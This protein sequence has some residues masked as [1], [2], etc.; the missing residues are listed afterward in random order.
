MAELSA[1]ANM[2]RD[3]ERHADDQQPDRLRATQYYNGE[4]MD[5]LPDAGRSKAVTRDVRAHIKKALPSICRTLLHGDELVEF[6][7]KGEGDEAGA[8]QSSDYINFVVL[9]ESGGRDA[10]YDAIHDALLLRNGILK[11][12]VDER[13]EVSVSRHS[14]IPSEAFAEL[15]AGD[16]VEVL[17]HTEREEMVEVDGQAVPFPVHDVKLRRTIQRKQIKAS[18]V[19]RERFLIHPDAVTFEDSLLTG[20]RTQVTRSDLVAMGYD[21]ETVDGIGRT[22]EDNTEEV[23]RRDFLSDTD[24]QTKANELVDY[25]EIFVRIDLD[26]DGIAEL[27]RMCFAGGIHEQNLLLNEECDEVQFCDL[28]AMRQPHQWE[29]ISIADDLM[30]LQR[31]KTVL[32]R[33]TLDN[34]YWTN[35]PQPVVNSAAIV[36]LDPVVN[37]DFGKAIQLNDGYNVR[38]AI[39]WN[40]IPFV[41]KE[42]FGMMDYIDAEAR[43]RT[44]ISEASAGMAPDALQNVTAKASAMIE[45]SGIGQTEMIVRNLAQ[46]LRRFFR[47]LLRLTI[48]HQD[49]PR[50]VRLRDEWVQIDPRQWNADMDCTVNTG[51]GAGTRERDMAVMGQVIGLQE[52]LFAAFGP[53]NPFVKP[54]NVYASISRMVEAAGLK[55]PGLYFT[56]PNPQEIAAKMQAAAQKPDPE[57]QKFQ[58]QMQ[59]EQ[60][61]LQT[62]QAKEK[63]QMDADLQVKQA[64]IQAQSIAQREKLEAEAALAAQRMSWEREKFTAELQLKREEMQIRRQDDMMK[65]QAA[66]VTGALGVA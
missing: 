49:V 16:D 15:A 40:T 4:M 26:D 53:D 33:Q 31:A 13:L 9:P 10:I 60:V 51:L 38:D 14:G 2:I 6:M 45:Q 21:R 61:K 59:L 52:K 50:T 56:E 8:E 1:V 62:Q 66:R 23:E 30:D 22:D 48:Q 42:S 47:G 36:D 24:A 7:P 3:A 55:T 54:E 12:W 44:G 41:A 19:P 58:A 17:E 37:P 29:G 64:E 27:R 65:A 63:A 46:G 34:L 25:Y 35:N 39:H 32:L 20:E 43:D 57:E 11:W 28:C 18:A 5:T